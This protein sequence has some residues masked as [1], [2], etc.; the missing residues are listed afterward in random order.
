METLN[1][2]SKLTKG[3]KLIMQGIILKQTFPYF[4]CKFYIMCCVYRAYC[5]S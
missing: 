3:T 2:S 4:C 1:F 5:I